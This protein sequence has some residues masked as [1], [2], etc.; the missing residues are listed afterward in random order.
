MGIPEE[1]D[2]VWW[3]CYVRGEADFLSSDADILTG[4]ILET[5]G[6]ANR[7]INKSY[8]APETLKSKSFV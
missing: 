8:N 1:D 5:K 4:G 6:T 7:C 2:K 3:K